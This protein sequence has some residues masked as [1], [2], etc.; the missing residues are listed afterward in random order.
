MPNTRPAPRKLSSLTHASVGRRTLPTTWRP[1]EIVAPLM[2]YSRATTSD[3]HHL[4]C[5]CGDLCHNFP[6]TRI[7]LSHVSMPTL[8]RYALSIL[9][10]SHAHRDLVHTISRPLRPCTHLLVMTHL[11]H[12]NRLGKKIITPS[13]GALPP[14]SRLSTSSPPTIKHNL[15]T[16]DM[17]VDMCIDMCVDRRVSTC[18]DDSV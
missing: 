10:H 9:A 15:N 13:L 18:T 11:G 14:H 4:P 2:S 5:V 17:C 8:P 3:P 16:V 7:F 1:C 12:R 6:E